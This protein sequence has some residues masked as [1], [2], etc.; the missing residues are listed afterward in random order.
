M[1]VTEPSTIDAAMDAVESAHGGI[2]I[3]VNCAG[4]YS[5][6]FLTD[7]TE[8]EFDRV[9]SINLKGLVFATRAAA[10]RMIARDAGGAIVNIASAA[11]RRP[12]P[13]SM[14]YSASKAGVISVTKDAALELAV[15]RIRANAIAPGAVETPMW[16]AVKL[17]YGTVAGEGASVE[18]AHVAATPLSDCAGR[19]TART[20]SCSFAP[21][22]AGLSPGRP[23]TSKAACT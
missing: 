1:D 23:S 10:R 12:S 21:R 13:W 19:A 9:L 8:A 22:R 6:K 18:A 3:L 14:V 11:G 17:A 16:D 2:D 20:R 5:M 7:V 15:H 4:V